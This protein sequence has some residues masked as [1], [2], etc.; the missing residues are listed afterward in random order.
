[1]TQQYLIR[2]FSDLLEDVEPSAGDCLAAAVDQRR[3]E[4]EHS[5]VRMLPVPASQAM[6]LSEMIG[7]SALERGDASSFCR[8]AQTA[9]GRAEF[10]DAVGLVSGPT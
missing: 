5:S 6:A 3:A 10:T 2:Q 7:W 4:V 8:Y 9:A 1:M